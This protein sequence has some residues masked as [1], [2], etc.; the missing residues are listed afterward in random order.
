MADDTIRVADGL[1]TFAGRAAEVMAQIET[2]FGRMAAGFNAQMLMAPP[3]V[4]VGDLDSIDYFANFP[5]LGSWVSPL[6]SECVERY[7]RADSVTEIPAQDLQAAVYG[8]P[9][10]ACYGVYTH[11]RDRTIQESQTYTLTRQ[12]FRCEDAYR[13]LDRL[14]SFHMQ[15]V[16]CVG[17]EQQV[18][19]FLFGGKQKLQE[20]VTAIGL[21]V[22]IETAQDPFFSKENPR[23]AMQKLF[24][25]KEEFQ[26]SERRLAIASV[27][28][29]HNF[30]GER[31]DIRLPDGAPAFTG[32]VAMGQERWMAALLDFYDGDFDAVETALAGC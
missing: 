25:T 27:N 26:F 20:I 9:S 21:P 7:T 1:A 23:L 10:A 5:H 13:D 4:R 14:W 16:V 22:V 30:F 12:C 29:H 3:L 19:K 32:C 15:E 28:F 24:P 8:L 31:F 2:R 17:A 11:L 6:R 18:K